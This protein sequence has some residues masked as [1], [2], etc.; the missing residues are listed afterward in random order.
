MLILR[1]VF[2]RREGCLFEFDDSIFLQERYFLYI[3][4]SKGNERGGSS[5]VGVG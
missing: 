2:E 3:L 4:R 5:L 1:G